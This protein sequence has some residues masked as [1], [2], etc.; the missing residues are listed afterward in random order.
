MKILQEIRN[1]RNLF[2]NHPL[3]SRKPL[4][5]WIRFSHF[6][7]VSV[8]HKSPCTFNWVKPLK[9]VVPRRTGLTG[10]LYCGLMDFEEMMFLLH[11]LREDD[12]FI[13]VGANA[14]VYSLLASKLAGARSMAFEP[15]PET[16][17]RLQEHVELNHLKEKIQCINQ[18]VGEREGSLRFSTSDKDCLNHVMPAD[19][20]DDSPSIEVPVTTLDHVSQNASPRMM[21]L[22]IE[23]YEWH[24]LKGG[25]AL[26]GS[27]EL[28]AI[29]MEFNL[30]AERYQITPEQV[31]TL[32]R[33]AG[34]NTYSYD[35]Y[36]RSLKPVPFATNGNSLWI[37]DVDEVVPVLKEAATFSIYGQNI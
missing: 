12:L 24:A 19:S 36:R 34:Y 17:A 4:T 35:P 18:G 2:N 10:N 11:F 8:L 16:Y 15:V 28:K 14:G 25:S 6:Q 22:D 7:L 23:G 31:E 5:P 13:D 3:W 27:K 32:L 1:L 30:H 37:K 21:K 20:Q 9:L 29:I 26:L 33:D